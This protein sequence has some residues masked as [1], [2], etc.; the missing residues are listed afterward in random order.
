MTEVLQSLLEKQKRS[1]EYIITLESTTLTTLSLEEGLFRSIKNELRDYTM[2]P[3]EELPIAMNDR[4]E[5]R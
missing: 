4:N 2:C 3:N 1:S 5:W